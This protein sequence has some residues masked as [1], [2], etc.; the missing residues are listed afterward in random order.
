M[1]LFGS[2]LFVPPKGRIRILLGLDTTIDLSCVFVFVFVFL[3]VCVTND[4]RFEPDGSL[5]PN[6][7]NIDDKS[8]VGPGYDII[9]AVDD[10]DDGGSGGGGK[11]VFIGAE[12]IGFVFSNA[13][14][15]S[16]ASAHRLL[17]RDFAPSLIFDSY[18]LKK[19]VTGYNTYN[20]CK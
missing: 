1:R 4:A 2:S 17:F 6:L 12:E 19:S 20:A 13:F 5:A 8:L 18:E 7:F 9:F 14:S 16:E 15:S 3:F 11:N 10:N